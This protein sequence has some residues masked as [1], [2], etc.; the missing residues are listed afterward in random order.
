MVSR[1]VQQKH[2][3]LGKQNLGKLDTHV[4]SLAESLSRPLKLIVTESQADEGLFC[5]HTRIVRTVIC[6]GIIDLIHS[7]YEVLILLAFIILPDGKLGSDILQ[8]ILKR[9]QVS[10]GSHRLVNDALSPVM[11]HYLRKIPYLHTIRHGN[12]S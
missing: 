3:R 2:V 8:L 9:K 1:L 12:L 10:E 5:H 11:L 6:Q 7:Y 4:P